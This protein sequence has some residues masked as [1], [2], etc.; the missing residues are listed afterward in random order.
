[1]K[2]AWRYLSVWSLPVV[3]LSALAMTLG[4]FACQTPGGGSG[5]AS[6]PA[7]ASAGSPGPYGGAEDLARA[8]ALWRKIRGWES[9]PA[10]PDYEGFLRGQSPHGRFVKIHM[11]EVTAKS[12]YEPGA[13]SVI[14]KANYTAEDPSALASLTVIEKIRGY[15]RKG[16]DWFWVAYDPSGK[17]VP[18]DDGIAQAGKVAEGT[19]RGCLACHANAGGKDF[20]FVNDE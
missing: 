16:A 13:G 17:V 6:A 19:P 14:V 7:S 1:M 10:Y 9:W 5:E 3:A 15:H 18:G 4:L 20:L 8:D 2:C 12:P 11:N